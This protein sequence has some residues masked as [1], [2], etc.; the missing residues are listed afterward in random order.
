MK[1]SEK[2][3]KTRCRHEPQ[4]RR[5]R[6][7][8]QTALTGTS[9]N[10]S[11]LIPWTPPLSLPRPTRCMDFIRADGSFV[12]RYLAFTE[13][14]VVRRVAARDFFADTTR[15]ANPLANNRHRG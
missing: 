7:L 13:L 2:Q 12:P 1:N 9:E 11:S 8:V 4:R 14:I 6:K 5:A 3:P 10:R 15:L